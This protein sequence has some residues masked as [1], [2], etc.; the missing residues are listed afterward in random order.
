MPTSGDWTV[1]VM[2]PD[3]TSGL[4]VTATAGATI[5]SLGWIAGGLFALGGILLIGGALLIVIP[6]V[7]ASRRPD[8]SPGGP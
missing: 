3:A 2:N 8:V 4:S 7:R 5:P 6:A 1:V